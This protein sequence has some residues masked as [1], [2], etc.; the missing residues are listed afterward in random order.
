MAEAKKVTHEEPA[1]ARAS[2]STDPAVHQV[3]A[4]IQSAQMN[5]DRNKVAELTKQLAELGYC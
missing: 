1:L 5:G 2:E 4:E 3:M